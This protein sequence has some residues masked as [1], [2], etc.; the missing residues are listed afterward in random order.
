MV[1]VDTCVWSLALRRQRRAEDPVVRQLEALIRDGR[2]QLIGPIRQEILA[3]IAHKA[4]FDRIRASLAAFPDLSLAEEDYEVAASYY[5]LC[6]AK[7]IQG[8][9]TDFLICAV[10][11]RHALEIFT[12]DEDFGLFGRLLPIVLHRPPT[13]RAGSDGDIAPRARERRAHTASDRVPPSD[14]STTRP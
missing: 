5:N 8:S 1:L 3:G 11:V 12:T 14:P 10:A 7:G 4:Q 6:R 9:N 2:A 13:S